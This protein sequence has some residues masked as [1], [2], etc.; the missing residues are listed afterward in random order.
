MSFRTRWLAVQKDV[1]EI[2]EDEAF[3][4]GR[5]EGDEFREYSSAY[6]AALPGRWRESSLQ[7]VLARA[8]KARAVIVGDYH[9]HPA[10]ANTVLWLLEELARAGKRPLVFLEALP[11][12]FQKEIDSYRN[13][14]LIE[15]LFLSMV[16]YR[17]AFGFD[18]SIYRPII[19]AARI[20]GVPVHGINTRAPAAGLAVRDAFAASVIGE[21]LLKSD[22]VAVVL[23]GEKHTAAPHLPLALGEAFR[24]RKLKGGVVTVHRNVASAYF[25]LLS[26]GYTGS[27][28]VFRSGG[29]HYLIQ[30]ASPLA[31]SARNLLWFSG[32][33]GTTFLPDS[34]DFEA[35]FTMRPDFDEV[36]LFNRVLKRTASLLGVSA[37]RIDDFH[38]FTG[39]DVYFFERF[40]EDGMEEGRYAALLARASRPGCFY[41]P[42]Y[43]LAY[44]KEISPAALGRTSTLHVAARKD[45]Q[46]ALNPF[47]EALR[48]SL[49]AALLDPYSS[50]PPLTPRHPQ[51][52]GRL[53]P[54]AV[55]EAREGSRLGFM[56]FQALASQSLPIEKV[57]PLFEG[58]DQVKR[59]L[60]R[61]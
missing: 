38:V 44:M 28:A 45:G 55:E 20:Y 12:G 14:D 13:G 9:T 16:G 10:S 15:G 8:L 18:W 24:S 51:L 60:D 50:R 19:R 3:P 27:P 35:G 11:D 33:G 40:R 6:E 29:G 49:G 39:D 56:V 42:E 37:P 5:E 43:S 61:L 17:T 23:V 36:G 21:R 32:R 48:G 41:V 22:T 59:V 7:D 58:E 4:F 2:L 54:E 46:G 1:F 25:A 52:N 57:P 26:R 53:Q 31:L 34:G 47:L 30:D